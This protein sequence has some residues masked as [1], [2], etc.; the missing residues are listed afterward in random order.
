MSITDHEGSPA[1]SGEPGGTPD[2]AA[3]RSVLSRIPS[4]RL[5]SVRLGGLGRPLALALALALAGLGA[6]VWA[7]QRNEGA[8]PVDRALT[9]TEATAKVVGDVGDALTKIFTYDHR[10]PPATQRS[11]DQVL[12][13]AASTQYRALFEDVKKQAPRQ[14]LTLTTRV[15]RAGVIDLMGDTARLLVFLDQQA[16]R[17][18]KPSGGVAPAQL[19][20]TARLRDGQWRISDLRSS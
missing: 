15:V 17:A 3:A 6:R 4:P 2:R 9:D 14:R 20:V 5:P 12:T 18:G 11:A 1:V 16:T 7:D 8:P 10:D 13:G 19:I